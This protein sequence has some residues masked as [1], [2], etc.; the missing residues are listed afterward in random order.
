MSEA[1]FRAWL[2]ADD[3]PAPL[4]EI[5]ASEYPEI[6]AAAAAHHAPFHVQR[7]LSMPSA[8]AMGPYKLVR[9][10][11]GWSRGGDF[12]VWTSVAAIGVS[13]RSEREPRGF[14]R[15]AGRPEVLAA[16]MR[17]ERVALRPDD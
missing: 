6:V 13:E 11:L 8:P 3:L 12:E 15:V 7:P 1:G 4:V 17:E 2:A 16:I 9:V 14:Q 5:V 10:Y